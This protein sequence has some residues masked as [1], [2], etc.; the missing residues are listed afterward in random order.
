MPTDDENPGATPSAAS[1]MP[2]IAPSSSAQP[3]LAPIFGGARERHQTLIDQISGVSI[4]QSRASALDDLLR[5]KIPEGAYK[6]H[7]ILE[8]TQRSLATPIQYGDGSSLHTL[9]E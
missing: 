7:Y 1:A 6:G 4:E 9:Y 3:A 5:L 2:S 8:G